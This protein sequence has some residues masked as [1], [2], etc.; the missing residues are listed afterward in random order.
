MKFKC[1]F[2]HDWMK[3]SEYIHKDGTVECDL[4]CQR[5][6]KKVTSVT[7]PGKK[8]YQRDKRWPF[9]GNSFYN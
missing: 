1:L 3:V 2:G 9:L 8:T 7:Q 4:D 5:C 6:G